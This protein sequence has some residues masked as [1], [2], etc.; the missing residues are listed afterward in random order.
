MAHLRAEGLAPVVEIPVSLVD[1]P[2]G[3]HGGQDEEEEEEEELEEEDGEDGGRRRR[4]RR[5]HFPLY[6]RQDVGAQVD[7][8]VSEN[9]LNEPAAAEFRVQVQQRLIAMGMLPRA[10]FPVTVDGRPL[11]MELFEGESLEAAAEAFLRAHAGEAELAR[12]VPELVR[13]LNAK[14][15]A[16]S[17]PVSL[18]GDSVAYVTYRHG[19]RLGE[20]VREFCARHGIADP[21]VVAHLEDGLRARIFSQ[22]GAA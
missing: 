20:V 17:V 6:G 1:G 2:V 9:E 3:A 4:G 8:F 14:Y 12:L 19:E 7:A 10:A 22:P 5:V 15:G 18:G 21:G 16:V 13:Q 11:Q